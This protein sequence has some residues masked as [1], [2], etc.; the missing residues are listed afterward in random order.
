MGGDRRL[1]RSERGRFLRGE[2][3]A[4]LRSRASR[5]ASGIVFAVHGELSMAKR[6]R[7]NSKSK[8]VKDASKQSA[9][10]PGDQIHRLAFQHGSVGIA[11]FDLEGIR[12]EANPPL[13][14]MLGWSPRE[15]REKRLLMDL[16]PP[17]W[18]ARNRAAWKAIDRRRIF[19]NIEVQFTPKR[20]ERL[21]LISSGGI[22]EID[23]GG[24]HLLYV[25]VFDFTA[26]KK[27]YDK[28]QR[29]N[30]RQASRI[31]RLEKRIS[32][33]V[34][35]LA[36]TKKDLKQRAKDVK[37]VNEAM[38]LLIVDFQEQKK[39]L[40]HR[41]V[42]NFQQTIE[43][44]IEQFRELNLPP[45][46]RHLLETL[47]FGIKHIASYFGINLSRKGGRLTPRQVEIC[48]MI[49]QGMDS[50]RI[51]REMGLTYQTIIVHRKNIRKRLGIDKT[52]QNLASFIREKM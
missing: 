50:H 43:P 2:R 18:R 1:L 42:N 40:E 14:R 30:N 24:N 39:D 46:Q 16:I 15:L 32:A 8:E 3:D 28:L 51:A 7:T 38:K 20:N 45:A 5:S 6:T 36:K 21:R 17:K 12:L 48:R 23:S 25:S 9:V 27:A 26:G 19:R 31:R 52:K 33:K 35:E 41:V 44:I 22:L 29:I 37:R 13:L 4:T 47:D 34:E 11:V 10:S 49:N